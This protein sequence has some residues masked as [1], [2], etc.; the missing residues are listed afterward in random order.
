[1]SRR[2]WALFALMSTV[3]GVPYMLIKVAV[4]GGVS[5]PVLVF[6]R[7]AIGAA[8][9]LPLVWRGG[10]LWQVRRYWRPALAFA[11]LEILAP[12]LLLSD[13]EQRLSSSTT[14]LLI[15]AAP[16]LGVALVRLTGTERLDRVRWAGLALGLVGVAA[17][18]GPGLGGGDARAVIEVVLTAVC[19]ALA[20][21]VADRYLQDVPTMPLT[22]ACLSFAALV[23]TPAA[24][25]TWPS[26]MPSGEVLAAIAALG[27]VCTGLAFVAYLELIKEAGPSRA[28]LF[29]Y[30]NPA[31]AVAA[32]VLLL[33]E[34]LTL[35]IVASFVLI[36]AGCA[37]ATRADKA[38]PP[39]DPAAR[40][41]QLKPELRS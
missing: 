21:L 20:P 38:A 10:Q 13:A 6:A 37:L 11:F 35:L 23:Y 29:I 9:L 28:L 16:I 4:V 31:V 14:G 33:N 22:V 8:L 17:L 36:M 39:P 3:W 41:A 26:A 24:I 5:A 25:W 34:P 18:V 1:M 32:G 40:P 12:W 15:A 19:Y 7:T 30:V 27:V 2:G